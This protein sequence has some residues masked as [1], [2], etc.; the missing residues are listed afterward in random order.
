MATAG[1]PIPGCMRNS[2]PKGT[3][4]GSGLAADQ[5]TFRVAAAALPHRRST[6]AA[7]VGK[8]EPGGSRNLGSGLVLG[9]PHRSPPVTQRLA[10]EAAPRHRCRL[11]HARL[12]RSSDNET[13]LRSKSGFHCH[14]QQPPLPLGQH[15]GHPGSALIE[16][17]IAHRRR[18]RRSVISTDTI[19]QPGHPPGVCSKPRDQGLGPELWCPK[20]APAMKR[21]PVGDGAW[22]A[23]LPRRRKP[24][25]P[26]N[27]M[28]WASSRLSG[29]GLSAT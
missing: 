20:P 21:R 26:G 25:P 2:L 9:P 5:R 28:H 1:A 7:A 6:P 16:H 24:R 4:C 22:R 18:R 23:S 17:P 12:P 19:R 29:S 14:N 10:V 15:L 11:A 27:S 13:R 3:C 8:P